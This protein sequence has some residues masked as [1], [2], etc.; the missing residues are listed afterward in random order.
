M[1]TSLPPPLSDAQLE[2]MNIIW[3]RGETTVGDVWK[4]LSARRPV[5]RNTVSTMV[6]RLEEKGWLRHRV[7][8]GSYLYSAT[9][10]RDKV[11][12][13]L[14]RRLVDAAFQ[15]SAEGLVLALLQGGRLSPEQ[16]ERIRAILD[17]PDA[18]TREKSP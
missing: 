12:P 10:P 6:T 16:L 17:R 8:E 9:Y 11:L 7:R 3:D 2:I 1:A 14:V 5:A 18:Q 13:R 4:V 15:G